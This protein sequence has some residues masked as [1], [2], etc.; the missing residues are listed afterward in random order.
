M[1][2]NTLNKNGIK[3]TDEEGVSRE[4][5]AAGLLARVILHENDHLNGIMFTDLCDPKT[6]VSR[7]WY[8]NNLKLKK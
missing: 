1:F 7:E 5:K 8:L 4:T 2:K 3:Y 6:L